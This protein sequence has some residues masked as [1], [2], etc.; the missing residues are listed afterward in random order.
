MQHNF[1]IP[2]RGIPKASL[3]KLD[4]AVAVLKEHFDDVVVA[5][6]HN[7]TRSIKVTSSNP[8]AGL[9]M[10]PTIQQHLK[11][12]IEHAELT[13]WLIEESRDDDRQ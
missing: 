3:D 6:T 12:S 11:S 7:E 10:L 5:V 2:H 9:G 1:N 8:Y 4:H 13:Q